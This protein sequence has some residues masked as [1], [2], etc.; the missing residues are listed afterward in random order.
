[1]TLEVEDTGPGVP[2][3][4]RS[5]I[6]DPFYTTKRIGEGTG[7]GLALVYGI[8]AD[9]GGTIEVRAGDTGGARFVAELPVGRR[10]APAAGPAERTQLEPGLSGRILIVDD[11]EPLAEMISDALIGDGHRTTVFLDARRALEQIEKEDYDLIISD[12]KMP[13]MKGDE[14]H[15][16]VK[17]LRPEM[18][19]KVLLTTGDTLGDEPAEI[20]ARTGLELLSKPF[21][22]D[23]LRR[24]VRARL[25]A[26][27]LRH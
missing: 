22:L 14:L 2:E 16:E 4:E 17:R 8:V 11:E 13:G 7:L 5:K 1:V 6:F 10:A 9:H 12:L 3:A 27:K 23:E 15:A 24:R 21:D 20:V 19:E 26:G 18:S 25:V